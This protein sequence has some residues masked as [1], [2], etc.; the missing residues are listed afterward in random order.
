MRVES[1]KPMKNGGWLHQPDDDLPPPPVRTT[2]EPEIKINA[3]AL[4]KGWRQKTKAVEIVKFADQ[5][6]VDPV[7][8]D[9]LGVAWAEEHRAWAFP[10]RYGNN[11][12]AGIRLRNIH[13][14]KWAVKGSKQGLFIPTT[15]LN[16]DLYIVEGPTDTAAALSLGLM[17][18]GRPSCRGCHDHVNQVI[19]RIRARRVV[20]VAD[21][22]DPGQQGAA[23]LQKALRITSLIWTP[24]T[25]DIRQYLIDGGTRED[26]QSRIKDMVWT[27][28]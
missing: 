21:N 23:D 6:Q 25:K 1:E 24:P 3:P 2:P 4:W 8:I 16:T 28:P 19:H 27:Q 15:A 26:I 9:V 7:A 18:I 10:M 22:D 5:L 20:I 17:A 12:I 11:G 14:D 13:G